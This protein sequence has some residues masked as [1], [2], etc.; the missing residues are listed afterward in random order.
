ML[1]SIPASEIVNVLPGVIGT[2]GDGLQ[3]SG[4]F[5]TNNVR[6]PIG[7]VMSFA[8]QATVA[9]Y[10]G[11][12]SA[13]ASLATVYFAGYDGKTQAPAAMLFYQYASAAVGAYLRGGSLAGMTLT[14][15]KALTGTLT[16]SVAGTPI[17]SSSISLT[18]ATSFSN[19]ATIIQ[20][21]F[22]SPGFV[23][24]FD[25]LSNAFVLTNTATGATSTLSFATGSLAAGIA[26]T[27]ATGAILSQGSAATDPMTAMQAVLVETTDFA[28]FALTFA[29]SN[30]ADLVTF[31]QWTSAQNNRYAFIM[32]DQEVVATE[33]DDTTS[34]GALIIAAGYSGTVPLY[35][36]INGAQAAAFV[37]GAG[38]SV[39]FAQ[40]NGRVNFAFLTQTGLQADVSNQSIADNLL[41]NG[42]DFYG[43]FGNPGQNVWTF[44]YNGG[45]TGPFAWLDSYFNEIWLNARLQQTLVNFL[46]AVKFVPY[47]SAGYGSIEEAMSGI[48]SPIADAVSFG[49]IQPGVTLN[50]VQILEV[51]TAAGVAVDD[52]LFQRGWYLQV[53]D[54][55]PTVRGQRGSPLITLFYCDGGSV[56]KLT[57]NSVLVS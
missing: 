47:N 21:A 44:L 53:K 32:W 26:L 6:V 8:N 17:T 24:S 43:R 25:S 41:A 57:V 30:L 22:T 38:A 56:N 50:S 11:A 28:S 18:A 42:Y 12:M 16:V 2:G 48:N 20:A 5:L 14:Q 40:A 36:P 52:V 7:S 9:S 13:E 29:P 54:P 49:M 35:A 46:L 33:A 34:A 23:V 10:F 31:A 15:L 3:L 4:L 27:Q 37:M 1:S 39:N 45:V 55:G 51:N 19:A